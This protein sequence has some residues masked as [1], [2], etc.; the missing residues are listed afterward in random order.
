MST[1]RIDDPTLLSQ[2][3]LP[4]DQEI[5]GIVRRHNLPHQRFETYR[6]EERQRFL[7]KQGRSRKLL[8]KHMEGLATDWVP[9]INGR[10]TWDKD[11]CIVLGWLVIRVYMKDKPV[12]WGG[13][14][15]RDSQFWDENFFDGAHFE[16]IDY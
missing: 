1:R 11:W 4:Y 5:W 15:D 16:R 7:V 10:W 9:K 13:D 6:L 14:W 2:K 8:S 12:R 3:W